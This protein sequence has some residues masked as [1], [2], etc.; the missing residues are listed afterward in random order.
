MRLERPRLATR[1]TLSL[2]LV[3]LGACS[4][5][6]GGPSAPGSGVGTLDQGSY[7]VDAFGYQS[8]HPAGFQPLGTDTAV[9]QA[10]AEVAFFATAWGATT[11]GGRLLDDATNGT[12]VLGVASDVLASGEVVLRAAVGNV[13]DDGADELA[14]L[15]RLDG[16][17]HVRIVELSGGTW[18]LVD[19]LDVPVGD[20]GCLAL[21]DVD[22]DHRD[23]I[24]VTSTAEMWLYDDAT[25][26][27]VAL[28]S[29]AVAASG[30]DR[31]EVALG[32]LDG[33]G[34][35]EVGFAK[36]RDSYS[37]VKA[38][39]YADGQLLGLPGQVDV[40][41]YGLGSGYGGGRL[42]AGDLDGDGR[43]ELVAAHLEFSLQ[44]RRCKLMR[45]D[46]VEGSGLVERGATQNDSSWS[47]SFD[48][49]SMWDIA[50]VDRDGDGARDVALAMVDK[51][52]FGPFVEYAI[53]VKLLRSSSQDGHWSEVETFSVPDQS[54]GERFALAGADTDAD[55]DDELLLGVT[56]SSPAAL[57]RVSWT[58]ARQGETLPQGTLS[59]GPAGVVR[60]AVGDFDADGLVLRSTGG[61]RITVADPI[62]LVLLSAAPTKAGV[63]QAYDEC[64]TSYAEETAAGVAIGVS[65]ELTSTI[66]VGAGGSYFFYSASASRTVESSFATSQVETQQVSS[67]QSFVAGA[68]SDV[69]VFQ[70]TLYESWE[71][72]VVASP[73]PSQVGTVLTLDAPVQAKTYKWTVD[74]YNQEF[75]PRHALG[76]DL[77]PHTVGDPTSYRSLAEVA[78]LVDAHVGWMDPLEHTTG[79]G[80]GY[81]G[82]EVSL[83]TQVDDTT[84]LT[85]GI[86]SEVE[87]S[88]AFA[89]GGLSSSVS[90]SHTYTVTTSHATTYGGTVGDLAG[91]DWAAWH[92]DF[93]MAV[94][95]HGVAAAGEAPSVTPLQVVTWWTAPHGTGY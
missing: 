22:G 29:V 68:E 59:A 81:N 95:Q 51:D 41:P 11:S 15:T 58:P 52:G 21:G 27:H 7:G 35:D 23:E 84:E 92:Y 54:G 74:K 76:A 55:G 60:L 79:E 77:L 83:Q 8:P 32:D 31:V 30:Y 12:A 50:L 10:R 3:A 65:T 13:D 44:E 16:Q 57:V 80:V 4:G 71:Y 56:N 87:F 37:R 33:D 34:R 91:D 66:S 26:N 1:L 53:Q 94:Y 75:G 18:S 9:L 28:A 5:G 38:F 73:D 46:F 67:V 45:V 47:S 85:F 6:G 82:T 78:A 64:S 36:V 70:G 17:R 40:V 88:A 48:Q 43:E 42:L 62:P 93:G 89:T 72:E 49:E 2:G 39:D 90:H 19:S 86:T 25:A 20:E 69:I 24:V 14:L 63:A 61:H